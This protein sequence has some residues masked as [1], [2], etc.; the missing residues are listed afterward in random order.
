MRSIISR[1]RKHIRHGHEAMKARFV[2]SSILKAT[3]LLLVSGRFRRR[4]AIG[5]LS[6]G[7]WPRL[8]PESDVWIRHCAL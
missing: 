3:V 8:V 4:S 7:H 6:L 5:W 1:V 2:L